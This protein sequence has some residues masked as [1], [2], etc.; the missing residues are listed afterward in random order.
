MAAWWC[1]MTRTYIPGH[2]SV[3]LG[4][5]DGAPDPELVYRP[6]GAFSGSWQEAASAIS[7]RRLRW[8]SKGG[9][10]DGDGARARGRGCVSR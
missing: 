4:D 8:S 2:S 7:S 3:A 1:W 10:L 9:L 5:R 6:H